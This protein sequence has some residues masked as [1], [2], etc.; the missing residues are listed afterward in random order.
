IDKPDGSGVSRV[1][2]YDA[3]LCECLPAAAP[4]QAAAAVQAWQR[5]QEEL[6]VAMSAAER[7]RQR[8]A[9]LLEDERQLTEDYPNNALPGLTALMSAQLSRL[10][11]SMDATR[12]DREGEIGQ[13]PFAYFPTHAQLQFAGEGSEKDAAAILDASFNMQGEGE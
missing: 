7:Y 4:A 12:T 10:P 8:H 9:R 5:A 13:Q 1:R 3:R 6:L 2:H 11:A